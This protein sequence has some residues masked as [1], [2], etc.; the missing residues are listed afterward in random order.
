MVAAFCARIAQADEKF[1]GLQAC[2]FFVKGVSLTQ[3]CALVVYA[4]DRIGS[5]MPFDILVPGL[6]DAPPSIQIGVAAP[7][8][9][10][11]LA[12]ATTQIDNS[13]CME[14]WFA[15]RVGRSDDGAT[16]PF[17][18][19]ALLGEKSDETP[20]GY[21]MRVDPVHFSINRGHVVLL[22][23][24]QLEITSDEAQAL[25][26]TLNSH[27]ANDRLHFVAP[28][29]HRWYMRCDQPV[30]LRTN[31]PTLTF[32]KNIADFWFDGPDREIWQTRQSEMQMLLHADAINDARETAGTLAV[33]GVWLW[34]A[35]VLP[36]RPPAHYAHIVGDDPLTKGIA[37][38]INIRHSN[39][40]SFN[41][42]NAFPG[43]E[44]NTLVL[45]D[46]LIESAAYG[47]W[48]TW[49][50]TLGALE[51]TWFLPALTNLKAG[52]LDCVS[53]IIP[54]AQHG[55]R[56]TTKRADLLKFWRRYQA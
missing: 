26:T 39:T 36:P 14:Y 54:H 51:R 25:V 29:P 17:A 37:I 46:A 19:F 23:A 5:D 12:R 11:L 15:K 47:D 6:L 24:S 40:E 8:L 49:Q 4:N 44:N 53:I 41:W 32:G 20:D 22:D 21:W 42:D 43:V 35:G 18:A 10:T 52:T 16:F 31:S 13:A 1:K 9:A 45:L 7:A 55:K 34:G 27:F 33:N 2:S 3:P 48:E 56:F 38:W 28:H 50:T 30:A